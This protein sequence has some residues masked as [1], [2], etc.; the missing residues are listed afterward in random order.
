LDATKKYPKI[1]A[2]KWKTFVE[3]KISEELLSKSQ[4]NNELSKKNI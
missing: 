3:Q 4:T 2:A 1:I